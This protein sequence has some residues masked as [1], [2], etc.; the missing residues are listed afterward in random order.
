LSVAPDL[1]D[2]TPRQPPLAAVPWGIG[3]DVKGGKRPSY[4]GELTSADTFGHI[5][6]TGTMVWADPRY[7]V[8]CVLLTNRAMV[9]G[10]TSERPRRAL[11]T[12]AVMAALVG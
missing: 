11:F 2:G 12:N 1:R 7:D 10:W 6:A 3:W 9:S 4:F 5:G 8:A